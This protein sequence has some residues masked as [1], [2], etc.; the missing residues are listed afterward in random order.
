MFPSQ[1]LWRATGYGS[2]AVA[3]HTTTYHLSGAREKLRGIGRCIPLVSATGC[4]NATLLSF[5][6]TLGLPVAVAL[7]VPL[8]GGWRAT[9]RSAFRSR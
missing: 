2:A 8:A 5:C 9:R 4:A 1:G 3:C 7:S 6:F